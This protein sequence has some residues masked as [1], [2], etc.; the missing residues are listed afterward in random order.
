MTREDFTELVLAH[1]SDPAGWPSAQ[2][3]AMIAFAADAPEATARA[4]AEAD[5]LASLLNHAPPAP[6]PSPALE[7]RILDA[8]RSARPAARPR[9]DL[10]GVAAGLLGDGVAARSAV[11][12]MGL[13]LVLGLG[14]GAGYWNAAEGARTAEVDTLLTAAGFAALDDYLAV[15]EG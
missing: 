10:G 12:A 2:R 15:D 5:A 1:G 14:F 9:F 8:F 3:A 6:A 11:G 7:A 4:A 13:A